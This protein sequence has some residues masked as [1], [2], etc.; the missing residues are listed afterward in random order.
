MSEPSQ[1]PKAV[2]AAAAAFSVIAAGLFTLAWIGEGRKTAPAPPGLAALPIPEATLPVVPAPLPALPPVTPP[3][4]QAPV[5][6]PTAQI[7]TEPEPGAPYVGEP[8]A[9]PE[10]PAPVII[11]PPAIR[12]PSPLFT[13]APPPPAFAGMPPWQA[14]A[15]AFKPIAGRPMVAV[16][17]DDMG[18][19]RKRSARTVKLPGP[20][21]LSWLPYA[22]DLPGQTAA[23]RA[24]GHELMLHLPMEPSVPANPGPDA[25]L[26][27]LEPAEILRRLDRAMGRFSGFVGINNH[28]GSRF[29]ADRAAMRPVL[30]EISRRGYFWLDSRTAPAS[31]GMA[32]AAEI[33]MPWAG[34]DVFLDHVMFPAEVGKA[35]AQLEATAKQRG[36]AVAIG[37]PHDVTIDAL[38]RWL[39]ELPKKGLVLAPMSAV[40]RA[41][42]AAQKPL[43]INGEAR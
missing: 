29:T 19:D 7:V 5:A 2:W 22:E 30:A 8:E 35:L 39:P 11:A 27:S 12:P 23:A 10:T 18:L 26:T 34:R 41:R 33:G 37:H 17:I 28:M 21:T 40:V 15:V 9:P 24:A 6:P 13:G 1:T 31:Q 16:V 36:F 25:L 14:N 38:A 32:A 3:P 4:V 20:L 42:Q 43:Q